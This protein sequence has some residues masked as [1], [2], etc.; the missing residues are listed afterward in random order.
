MELSG[1]KQPSYVGLRRP[2][3]LAADLFPH[4]GLKLTLWRVVGFVCL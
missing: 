3:K 1:W 4:S 2:A